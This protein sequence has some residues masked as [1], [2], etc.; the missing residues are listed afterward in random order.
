[1]E[2]AARA[3]VP[4]SMAGARW[5]FAKA[6]EMVGKIIQGVCRLRCHTA[7]MKREPQ[8]TVHLTD[9]ERAKVEAGLR[10]LAEGKGRSLEES[11]DAVRKIRTKWLE[12]NR[13]S[14]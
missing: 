2:L 8:Q 9:E 10:S 12:R 11:I 4:G 1:M 6:I 7:G 3:L 13:E 5:L 14:A